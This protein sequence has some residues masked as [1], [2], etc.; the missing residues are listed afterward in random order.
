MTDPEPLPSAED[1]EGMNAGGPTGRT[2]NIRQK[3]AA[4]LNGHGGD[5]MMLH[6]FFSIRIFFPKMRTLRSPS[7]PDSIRCASDSDLLPQGEDV[8]VPIRTG[9][10]QMRF[11]FRSSSAG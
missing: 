8:T 2:G 10:H 9:Q 7:G 11:R 4:M 1:A 6:P 3:I 5:F